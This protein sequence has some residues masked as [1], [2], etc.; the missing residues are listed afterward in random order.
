[1]RQ[2][3]FCQMNQIDVLKKIILERRSCKPSSMNGKQ[4]ETQVIQSLL[5]LADWAPTHGRTEP[6]RFIVFSNEELKN[7]SHQH[8]ELYKQ[9]TPEDKFTTAK[10]QGI[11][12]NGEK[13]SHLI[14]VF[15]KRQ[16]TKK[17]PVVEEI[18][19]TSAAI[20]HILLGAQAAGIA[21]LW[22]TGGMT[23]HDS[24]KAALGL[25]EED[26]MMGLLYLGYAD[27][28]PLAGKRNIPLSEKV[29]WKL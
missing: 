17:I 18:A 1:M 5:E 15:M 9:H 14:A 29:I 2:T 19:A 26:Q 10:Y 13:C 27:E 12:Q 22:S 4:I 23:Y 16:A 28:L 24:M 20:E 3:Y 11:L 25:D 8:A 7:F 6:W 21:A